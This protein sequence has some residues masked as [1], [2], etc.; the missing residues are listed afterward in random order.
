M[1][2]RRIKGCFDTVDKLKGHDPKVFCAFLE[3]F[4]GFLKENKISLPKNRD[5]EK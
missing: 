3:E 1:I 2:R 4:D 5:P